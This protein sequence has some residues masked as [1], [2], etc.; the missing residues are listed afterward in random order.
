[1]P[2]SK[3]GENMIVSITLSKDDLKKLKFKGK[4]FGDMLMYLNSRMLDLQDV[5]VTLWLVSNTIRQDMNIPN[6]FERGPLLTETSYW[7]IPGL[8]QNQEPPP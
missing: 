4:M 8:P 1:M 2:S 3:K 6:S 7:K 5:A